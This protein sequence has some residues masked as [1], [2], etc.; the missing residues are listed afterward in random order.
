MKFDADRI[1]NRQF[2]TVP[3]VPGAVRRCADRLLRELSACCTAYF[4]KILIQNV[5]QIFSAVIV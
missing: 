2:P 1:C 5:A 3:E 4:E